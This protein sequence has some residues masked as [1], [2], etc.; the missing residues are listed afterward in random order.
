MDEMRKLEVGDEIVL[1][2]GIIW[3][4]ISYSFETVKSVTEKYVNTN[5]RT[6]LNREP[7]DCGK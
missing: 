7:V 4:C 1:I 6:K 2:K 3:P 5:R